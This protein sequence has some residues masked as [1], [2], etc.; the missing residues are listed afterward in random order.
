MKASIAVVCIGLFVVSLGF[1]ATPA[2]AMEASVHA[3][4]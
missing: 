2:T 1:V 4:A 3:G